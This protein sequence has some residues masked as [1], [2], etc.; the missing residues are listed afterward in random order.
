[1]SYTD[2]VT[3]SFCENLCNPG[4]TSNGNLEKKCQN[5]DVSCATC[6][7]NGEIGD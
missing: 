1:M 6:I 3:Q 4:F 5:C 7:D 2:G